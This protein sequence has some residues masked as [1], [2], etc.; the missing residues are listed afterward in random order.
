[1]LIIYILYLCPHQ[2]RKD[3]VECAVSE[4]KLGTNGGEGCGKGNRGGRGNSW[5][6]E[7]GRN[8]KRYLEEGR[9]GGY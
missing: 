7:V 2:G 1:M 9:R 5:I 8:R 6:S 3:E 4:K